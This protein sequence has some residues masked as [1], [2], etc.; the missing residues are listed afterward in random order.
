[1]PLYAIS[2]DT[3]QEYDASREPRS[4][5]HDNETVTLLYRLAN[6]M[7][8][9]WRSK[10]GARLKLVLKFRNA[11]VPRFNKPLKLSCL[12]HTQFKTNVQKFLADL[13][14][15]R[16]HVLVPY[17]LPTKTVQEMPH[18]ALSKASWNHKRTITDLGRDSKVQT[19]QCQEF[20]KKH[21]RVQLH[22][23]HVVT[24]LETLSLPKSHDIFNNVGAGNAFFPSKRKL[25]Q[26]HLDQ[27]QAWIK[28]HQCP[29][30][31][32]ILDEF[33]QFFDK[34][35]LLHRQQL[36][37]DPRLTHRLVKHIISIIPKNYIIH[38]EDH[39]N[40]HLMTYCP[41][42]Y[43]QAAY[44]T[45]MDSK[46]FRMLDKSVQDIKDDVQNNTPAE[47]SKHYK[48]LMAYDKP[49]PY[50]YIMMK[51][52]NGTKAERSLPTPTPA[53]ESSS[54]LQP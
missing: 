23:G 14:R 28:H 13:T 6:H 32:R 10:A 42:I 3:R 46:T 20:A 44:N 17:R 2:S 24:G 25:K 47:V 35:W 11:S 18:Q 7:E 19:C 39:A 16:R 48:K 30:D 45:W 51:R 27:F 1:M 26:E 40:A 15:Q 37:K 9:P 43:N 4:G 12:A 33:E 36:E 50:G 5:K 52:K 53:L 38:N 54:K 34:E 49:L 31:Q 22:Q 29:L 41:N 8:Q 21:P